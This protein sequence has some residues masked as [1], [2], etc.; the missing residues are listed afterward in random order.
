MAAVS[1]GGRAVLAGQAALLGILYLFL[2]FPIA[3]VAYHTQIENIVRP[4]APHLGDKQFLLLLR[5]VL[6]AFTLAALLFA[7]NS[8]SRFSRS[9]RRVARRSARM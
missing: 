9:S 3:N 1:P 6:V 8:T 7:L 5:V 4:F 2:Y